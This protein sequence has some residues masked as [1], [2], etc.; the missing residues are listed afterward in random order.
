[1][2]AATQRRP[3]RPRGRF[4]R[5]ARALSIAALIFVL[6]P[7][8]V[9]VETMALRAFASAITPTT[10][11]LSCLIQTGTTLKPSVAVQCSR[12]HAAIAV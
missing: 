12:A 11:A 4:V 1:M 7:Y 2:T 10:T 6:L 5:L 8:L 9:V 3:V